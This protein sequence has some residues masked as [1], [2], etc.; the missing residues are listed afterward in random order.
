MGGGNTRILGL[1]GGG[2]AFD[3]VRHVRVAAVAVGGFDALN[4]RAG[5]N[6]SP[7]VGANLRVEVTD[8]LFRNSMSIS[9]VGLTALGSRSDG[10]TKI[11]PL[12]LGL[13]AS[14]GFGLGSTR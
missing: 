7:S 4:A 9:L 12:T 11:D 13:T 5:V 8:L 14:I 3:V 2:A 6:F 10:D 1:V